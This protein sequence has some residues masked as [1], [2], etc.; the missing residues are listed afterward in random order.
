VLVHDVVA[1]TAVVMLD[2]P[3]SALAALVLANPADLM[4]VLGTAGVPSATGGNG[5]LAATS[6]S[7][8]IVVI[9]LIAWTTLTAGLAGALANRRQ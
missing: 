2:L 9:A 1:L 7:V 3:A 4:R 8:P 5:A 6:L